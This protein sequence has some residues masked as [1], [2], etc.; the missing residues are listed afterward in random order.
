MT[1]RFL[2]RI[3][4]KL[5]ASPKPKGVALPMPF[6]LLGTISVSGDLDHFTDA[7]P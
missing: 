2:R 3:P 7:S 1:G 5:G 6:Q 4:A